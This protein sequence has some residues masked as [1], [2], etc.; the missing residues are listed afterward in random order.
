[1]KGQ[2]KEL[3]AQISETLQQK[4]TAPT[5]ESKK[6]RKAIKD[7]ATKLAKKIV[8]AGDNQDKKSRK[9]NQGTGANANSDRLSSAAWI[10]AGP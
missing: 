6:I 7:T 1:M 10:E 8:K 5:S 2:K 9:A 3:A 4:L